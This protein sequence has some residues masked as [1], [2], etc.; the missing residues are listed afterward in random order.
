MPKLTAVVACL[1]VAVAFGAGHA[2]AASVEFVHHNNTQLAAVLQ[3]VH[4]RCPDVS[5]LYTL[6]ESSVRGVPLYV[7]EFSDNPGR[8]QEN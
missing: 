2:A 4:N 8:Q 5:R 7:L 1:L 3:R 6:S